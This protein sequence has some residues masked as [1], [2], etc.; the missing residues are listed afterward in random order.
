[1]A[2]VQQVIAQTEKRLAE[3]EAFQ[4]TIDQVRRDLCAY[5]DQLKQKLALLRSEEPPTDAGPPETEPAPVPDKEMRRE[6]PSRSPP[7]PRPPVE[8]E[9]PPPPRSSPRLPPP[10]MND[11][12][13]SS[14]PQ[15]P[16]PAVPDEAALRRQLR[17]TPAGRKLVSEA[18]VPPPATE[19]GEERRSSP[20]RKGNPISVLVSNA[21]ATSEPLQ[22]WVVDRS[23]GGVRLLVDQSVAPG[24]VLSVR[25]SKAHPGYTWVQ[26]Q[27]R[28]CRPERSSYNLGCMFV[29]KLNW[30]E[31]QMFG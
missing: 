4:G 25:P 20:R 3:V 2:D 15:L 22:G 11:E 13:P 9:I 5:A 8:A 21:G 12:P 27:V 6:R 28:S 19:G 30:A 24:T 16:R 17:P 31:L 23:A 10:P 7:P 29:Q 26:I 14:S 18:P 1:M